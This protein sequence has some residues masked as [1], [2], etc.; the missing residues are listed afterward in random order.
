MLT[1]LAI[2]LALTAIVLTFSQAKSKELKRHIVIALCGVALL[3]IGNQFWVRSVDWRLAYAPF[4]ST[5]AE[6]NADANL[7]Q[8][9][10]AG[11]AAVEATSKYVYKNSEML[12]QHQK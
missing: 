6:R 12:V 9:T 3:P 11:K 4:Y 7:R 1:I 2:L 10:A 8:A 5:K